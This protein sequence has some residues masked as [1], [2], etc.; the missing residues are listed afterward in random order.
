MGLFSA[1]AAEV[2]VE[3][4]QS[5]RN[6][7][8]PVWFKDSGMR[9]LAF[10]MTMCCMTMI[11]VGYDGAL[12]TGLQANPFWLSYLG[13]MTA[14][15]ALGY[16]PGG[17]TGSF[18]ADRYGRKVPVI[19]GA[20]LAVAGMI[21]QVTAK[22]GNVFLGSRLLIG[23]SN[24]MSYCISPVLA[25]ELA[26]PRQRGP[27]IA[28]VGSIIAAWTT[29]GTLNIKSDWSWRLPVILQAMGCV[30]QL[31]TIPF[32]PESP[33]WLVSRGQND[34]ALEILAR[35]HANGDQNDELVQFEIN[36]II[37]AHQQTLT[38]K[39]IGTWRDL[40]ATPGNRK[41]V[42]ICLITSIGG[43]CNG[44]VIITYYLP[45]ILKT[46]G[47]TGATQQTALFGGL[48]IW[49]LFV[50]VPAALFVDRLGRRKIWLMTYTWMLVCEICVT[51]LSATFE[52][53]G[54][55]GAGIAVVVFLYLVSLAKQSR[56]GLNVAYPC[57]IMPTHLRSKG[58]AIV[59]MGGYIAQSVNQYVNPVAFDA[60]TWK[61]YLV[62]IVILCGLITTFYFYFPE[63][64]GYTME[65]VALLFDGPTAVFPEHVEEIQLDA[66]GDNK[67]TLQDR[68]VPELKL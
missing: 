54:S 43:Q 62:Y 46:V 60:I 1:P 6:N 16:I 25:A 21:V 18:L 7:T 14:A 50:A 29:F 67:E 39:N 3:T 68:V 36:E 22:T 42:Y 11:G 34:K 57:E 47:V 19:V 55:K 56:H 58:I 53:T 24:G 64:R 10:W 44:Y 61:Y 26:H 12:L 13:I 30:V 15:I 37:A 9:R 2:G 17:P 4:W 35:Y 40:L 49:G 65:E 8:N 38:N 52:N 31:F 27:A 63:T 33:R 20:V 59:M 5:K 45:Q 41:R 51:A 48:S 32:A 23:F 66:A 28:L